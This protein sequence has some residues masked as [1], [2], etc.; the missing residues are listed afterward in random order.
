[1]RYY[2]NVSYFLPNFYVIM[3]TTWLVIIL[4]QLSLLF[5]KL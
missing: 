1:M 3:Y 5:G 2:Y 4:L